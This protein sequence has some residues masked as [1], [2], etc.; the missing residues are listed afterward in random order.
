[1]YIIEDNMELMHTEHYTHHPG[2]VC[3]SVIVIWDNCIFIFS[4]LH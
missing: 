1:M 2:H 4:L 3:Y